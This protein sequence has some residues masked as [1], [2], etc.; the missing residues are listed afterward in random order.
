MGQILLE[1]PSTWAEYVLLGMYQ[2]LSRELFE[3]EIAV[4]K[5]D[6]Q[7]AVSRM[8]WYKSSWKRKQKEVSWR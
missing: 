2:I 7:V 6:G 1:M 5:W 4:A 8:Y 3:N